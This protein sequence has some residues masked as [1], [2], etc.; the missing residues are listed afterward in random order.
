MLGLFVDEQ[1]SGATKL[2]ESLRR[3]AG[4]GE[5]GH[6][7]CVLAYRE[8]K[9]IK[10]S[11]VNKEIADPTKYFFDYIAEDEKRVARFR[12]AMGMSTKSLAFRS[13]YFV[14]ALPWADKSQCPETVV[15]IGGAGGDLCHLG[16]E[17]LRSHICTKQVSINKHI[18]NNRPQS[19]SNASPCQESH[20][21]RPTRGCC[22]CQ[23]PR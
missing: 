18:T 21:P 23:G 16:K 11:G 20:R 19:T 9:A 3:F 22:R 7:A 17:P 1:L 2:A 15:D 6:S 14:D 10:G 4:S 5:P 8:A 12:S 13:S